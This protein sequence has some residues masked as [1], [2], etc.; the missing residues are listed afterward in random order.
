[1]TESAWDSPDEGI[2]EVRGPRR[3]FVHSKVMSW[4][5]FDRMSKSVRARGGG[6]RLK[7]WERTRDEIHAEVLARGFDASVGAFTQSYGSPALD[8]AALVIPQ[9]GFLPYS[10]PR[11]VSTVERIRDRLSV[12]GLILRYET[13]ASA[14]DGT[15]DGLPEGEGAFLACSFWLVEALART[16]H[17]YQGRELFEHLLSLR[18]DVGLLAE[19]YDPATKRQVGNFPQA[20]SHVPLVTSA[21]A[22]EE[23]RKRRL[24]SS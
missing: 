11:V 6:P 2:W 15:D 21:V 4:V 19:E 14:H 10:D 5:A 22:L 9:V 1:M 24:S 17:E 23:V 13:D 12:D 16:G 20:F 8:A 7:R 3:H 18:N